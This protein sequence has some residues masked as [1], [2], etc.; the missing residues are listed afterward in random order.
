MIPSKTTATAQ[1]QH[2][3]FD[4]DVKGGEKEWFGPNAT[5]GGPNRLTQSFRVAI[6]A[7]GED[8]WHIYR[9][10]CL[11]LMARSEYEAMEKQGKCKLRRI[12]VESHTVCRCAP[13]TRLTHC[14]SSRDIA[15]SRS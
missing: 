2:D 12:S 13:G 8:C 1:G 5:V 7:K 6:N 10:V 14:Q 15:Y 9:Q 4:I 11:S 3:F